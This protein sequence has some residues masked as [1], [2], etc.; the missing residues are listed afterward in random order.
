M[1]SL[2]TVSPEKKRLPKNEKNTKAFKEKRS[3]GAKAERTI[4]SRRKS[5]V[6]QP[7]D[8]LPPFLTNTDSVALKASFQ[9]KSKSH[10][11]EL[12]CHTIRPFHI[13]NTAVDV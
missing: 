8:E 10:P 11:G 2:L 3:S 1:H 4:T 13:Q 5:S 7:D 6:E 12:V 9:E